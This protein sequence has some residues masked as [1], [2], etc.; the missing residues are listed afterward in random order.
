MDFL[1]VIIQ[2]D[3]MHVQLHSNY[4]C[5]GYISKENLIFFKVIILTENVYVHLQS[6]YFSA[7]CHIRRNLIL[8]L[9]K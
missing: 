2:K 3:T 1:K 4:F 6:N 9:K 5:A 7:G 8:F